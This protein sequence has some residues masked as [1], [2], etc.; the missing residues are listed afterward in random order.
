[1]YFH[2]N[3]GIRNTEEEAW[4]AGKQVWFIVNPPWTL[5]KEAQEFFLPVSLKQTN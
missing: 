5:E 3:S 4:M 1:M 2:L